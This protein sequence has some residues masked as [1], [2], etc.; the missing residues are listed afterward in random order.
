MRTRSDPS[1]TF[2]RAS[3]PFSIDVAS[4]SDVWGG[5]VLDIG[6]SASD[7][8]RIHG[9]MGLGARAWGLRCEAHPPA[10]ARQQVTAR[11]RTARRRT[12]RRGDDPDDLARMDSSRLEVVWNGS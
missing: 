7:C 1:G 12:R 5:I 10:A 3:Q 9:L 6:N 4:I 2:S 8:T 11:S